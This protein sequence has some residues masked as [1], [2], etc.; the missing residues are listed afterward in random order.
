MIEWF[1]DFLVRSVLAS[2]RPIDR[3]APTRTERGRI[4]MYRSGWWHELRPR[5]APSAD[6]VASLDVSVLQDHLLAPILG[7]A[8]PRTD[9]RIR[10]A[11]GTHSPAVLQTWVEGEPVFD[12]SDPADYL[13]AVG[14]YGAG[15]DTVPYFCCFDHMETN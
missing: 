7:I 13:H 14:G 1:D 8:D 12:R 6:P 2:A 3:V 9:P 15:N 11:G 4:H 5:A 10:F